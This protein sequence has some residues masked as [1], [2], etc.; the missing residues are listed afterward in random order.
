MLKVYPAIFHK[1]DNTY[2]VEWPD[3]EGCNT[4]GNTLENTMELAQEAMGLYL[5][6]LAENS[7]NLPSPS[8]LS[9][10]PSPDN[11]FTSL[12]TSEISQYIRNTRAV[13][14]TL[15]IPQWLS[16][17]AERENISLSKVL[18]EAL[19]AQLGV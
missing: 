4:C 7:Q 1:E 9:D 8:N 5:A 11:G 18:Q 16:D 13:K 19:K 10:I 6:T 2:W 12:V 15:S 14:K 17:A 3:L